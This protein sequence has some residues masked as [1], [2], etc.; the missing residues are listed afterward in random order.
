VTDSALELL[1]LF[2]AVL[3]VV[4]IIM[5]IVLFNMWESIRDFQDITKAATVSYVKLNNEVHGTR[6]RVEEMLTRTF[7]AQRDQD[8]IRQ[9]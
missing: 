3:A 8:Q 1:V 4:Q 7:G 2:C 5:L 9:P 6:E